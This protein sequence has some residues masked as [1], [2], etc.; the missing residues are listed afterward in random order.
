MTQ[1]ESIKRA[2]GNESK[3]EE[4]QSRD[5]NANEQVTQI[6]LSLAATKPDKAIKRHK[7]KQKSA[8]K[9]ITPC[10]NHV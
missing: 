4:E 5:V 7:P 3:V 1:Y 2:K 8:S 6:I 9:Q 10:L